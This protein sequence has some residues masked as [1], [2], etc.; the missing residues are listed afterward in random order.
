MPR[1]L[2]IDVGTGSARAGIVDGSGALLGTGEAA[3]GL[4]RPRPGWAQHASADIWQAV[5]RATAAARAAAGVGGVDGIGMD[6]TCSL[7]AAGPDGAPVSVDPDGAEDQDVIVWMDHRALDDAAEINA[8]GGDPLAHVGGRIS[9][10]MQ[11]PKLRWLRREAPDAWA[12]AARVWDLSDW[13][14]HHATGTEARSLCAAVCKWTYMGHRGLQGEGWD[15][16]FLDA[17]GLGELTREGRARIG[18]RFLAPGTPAGVLDARAADE[19]GLAEG[20]P[21]GAALIDAH[22]GALGTLGAGGEG[23]AGRLA[24]IAGTSTCHIALSPEPAFVPGVWGPYWGAV[25]PGTWCN[26]GGQSAAGA[27]LDAVIARH[28]AAA[29]LAA[30]PGGVHA[31]LAERLAA[32]AGPGGETATLTARRHVQPDWHGNRSPLAE[33][34]RRGT[35]DGLTLETGADDLALDYL[36]AIQALAYGTRHIVEEMRAAGLAVDTLVPSGGLARSELFL[37]EMADATACAVACPQVDEP[38]LLGAAML[39]AVAAGHHAD[40]AAAMAAMAPAAETRAPRPALAGYHDRKYRVFRRMQ[41]DH[42]AYAEIMET[43]Q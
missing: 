26:E 4:W 28:A 30:A 11:M 6:A 21:V 13:L 40:A 33:P 24:V 18:S 15:D 2:G 41:A 32:L 29:E 7:V 16:G 22:A 14:V 34:W 23:A 36:A 9:P 1:Y 31:A 3:I 39:G 25:T 10:E 27:L 5:C 19:L 12:R 8:I 35:I 42:A 17:I 37:R 43:A 20:T 38:V